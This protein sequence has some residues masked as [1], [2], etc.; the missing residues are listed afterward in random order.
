M[1]TSDTHGWYDLLSREISS[2]PVIAQILN[3]N[4]AIEIFELTTHDQAMQHT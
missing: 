2:P 4:I 3:S 1:A